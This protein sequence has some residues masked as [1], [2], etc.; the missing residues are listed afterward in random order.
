MKTITFKE[1]L[2]KLELPE[3][4]ADILGKC[5]S[6]ILPKNRK[7]L[8]SLAVNGISSGTYEVAYNIPGFGR[9]VEARVSI[10]KNGLSIN[11]CDPYMRR[12][13]P[14]C[15]LIGDQKPTD[16]IRFSERFGK[17]FEPIRHE[18]FNWLKE[19]NLIVIAF[20]VGNFEPETG[21][22]ALLIAPENTG[23]FIGALADLQ[24][25]I[26]PDRIPDN[27][28]VR[29]VIYLAP[30]FRHTHF[31]GKQIV[32]HNR[33][34]D[35]YEVFSY[36]LYP[37]PSA[38]KGVY[39]ILLS[40]GESERWLTLHGSTVQVITPY[41]NITNIMHEGASGGGKSEMIEF[42]HRQKDGRLLLGENTI[43]GEKR[44]LALNQGCYLR[45]VTDDMALSYPGSN[46]YLIA[47]DAEQAWFVRLNHI[48]SYGTDPNLESIIINPAEPL[49]FLNLDGTPGATCLPWE[50]TEDSPGK[51][52]PNPRVILPRRLIPDVINGE[53]EVHIRNFGI[54]TPPCTA[55][56]P[57]FG[58]VGYLHLLPPALAWLW[59]LVA[60]RGHDNP[61]IIKSEGLSSEGVGSYWPFATGRIVDHANLLLRQIL[62]TPS[63]RYTL[64]PNQ[65]VGAWYVSF[66]P[67]W[68]AREYL[69]RRGIA[70]YQAGQILP[71]RCPLLGYVL[72]SMQVEGTVLPD[73]L[74]RVEEQ[75]E[76][77]E[78]GYDAGARI[79]EQF[80]ERELKKFLHPELDKLG[81]QIIVCC[82]DRGSI[83]D[84]EELIPS[85]I[86]ATYHRKRLA[87]TT[88]K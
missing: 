87:L 71:A 35:L 21:H 73:W 18:T 77:G 51:P 75:H 56:R 23:F 15:L 44:F 50:H 69:A 24:G 62:E 1:E 40:I 7:E 3:S 84:Y 5:R 61:S 64:T 54:R 10:C 20:M 32:V 47:S 74:L 49:I 57:T 72:K 27:F 80:F 13:D 70:K 6:V 60:P 19:Q 8:F 52:C 9:V 45:P 79:L 86:I 4:I 26:P 36:N 37:G 34:D 41:D 2:S 42:I 30:P 28:K 17:S 78:E 66:M 22:G 39:G 59:R 11:Y 48:K 76:V 65:H 29:N 33:L 88:T 81:K 68:V 12:R 58:I 46:G 38:K 63:V 31:G 67:Q 16:K 25:M 14:D 85:E 83:K 43:T 55:Q 82:L 53:V